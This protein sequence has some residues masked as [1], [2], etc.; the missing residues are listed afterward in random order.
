MKLVR[1]LV[2]CALFSVVPG[3]AQKWEFGA[4][5][6]GGFYT[7]HDVSSAAGT[8]K[9]GI[10]PGLAISTW[11][12]NNTSKRWGGELRYDYQRGALRL[13]QDSTEATFAGDS[14]AIHYDFLYHFADRGMKVRPFVAFGAGIKVIR[15]TGEPVVFQPLSRIAILTQAQDVVPVVS[16]AVGIKWKIT[17]RVQLRADVHDYL[18]PFPKE[19]IAPNGGSVDVW[20]HDIVPM[21]SIVFTN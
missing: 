19:A 20:M 15:G 17:P 7:S 16:G 11:L 13:K 5:A 1:S 2:V 6:G 12:G 4:G 10:K 14:H 9:A 8:A 21:F 3:M 18:T